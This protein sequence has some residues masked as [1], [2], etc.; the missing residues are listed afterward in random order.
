MEGRRQQQLRKALQVALD[1]SLDMKPRDFLQFFPPELAASHAHTLEDYC[2][3][4]TGKLRA[5]IE[6]E[7]ETI[8]TEHDM[9]RRLKRLDALFEQQREFADGSRV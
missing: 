1:R 8:C 7:F 2:Q 6:E 3:Q 4:V 9:A 5:N